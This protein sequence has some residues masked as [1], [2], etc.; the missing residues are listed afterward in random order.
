MEMEWKWNGDGTE[1]ECHLQEAK[2]Q[3]HCTIFF[4]V[5]FKLLDSHLHHKNVSLLFV[6]LLKVTV[7]IEYCYSLEAVLEAIL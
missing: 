5:F 1:T 7:L 6:T 4:P 3:I 2:L